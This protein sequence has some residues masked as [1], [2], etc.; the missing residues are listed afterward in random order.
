M[1]TASALA[2]CIIRAVR[3][4]RLARIIFKIRAA[5]NGRFVRIRRKIRAARPGRIACSTD[6]TRRGGARRTTLATEPRFGLG[7]PTSDPIVVSPQFSLNPLQLFI[8]SEY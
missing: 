8:S 1:A 5:R 2:S 4:G 7:N 3:R 6:A